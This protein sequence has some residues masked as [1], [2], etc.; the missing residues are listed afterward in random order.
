MAPIRWGYV[1]FLDERE[2]DVPAE[3][4]SQA[5]NSKSL[6][7]RA[8][9]VAA[10]P[11]ANLLFALVA[12]WAMYLVGKQD[13]MPVVGPVEGIA[14][15]A[16]VQPGDRLLTVDG[17]AVPTWTHA[18]LQLI[19]A[20]V[21]R[22]PWP[23]SW[24]G[25]RRHALTGTAPGPPRR[26]RA[27]TSAGIRPAAA[28]DAPGHHR[29]GARRAARGVLR[30]CSPCRST[31]AGRAPLQVGIAAAPLAVEYDALLRLG[32]RAGG[33]GRRRPETWTMT[34]ATVGMLWRMVAGRARGKPQRPDQHFA[35][36][37]RLG[38][39]WT[40]VLWF[41]GVI[42]LSLCIINLLPIPSR[43]AVTCC[44]P[45]R[46]GQGFPAQQCDGGG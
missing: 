25:R 21:D 3:L 39:Q 29:T 15:E 24:R 7:Q 34:A 43:T 32:P 5:F 14:A 6:G 35:L 16:G 36:C 41:L 31:T 17:V 4:R 8:A 38:T 45:Y 20:G 26:R 1:K 23:W 2:G 19:T 11:A 37:Q 10:G 22:R 40:G 13:F 27:R 18:A 12:F 44:I 42:S 9:I 46:V 30:Q 33:G 28:P